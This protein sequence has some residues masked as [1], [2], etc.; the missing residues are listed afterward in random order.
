MTLTELRYVMAVAAFK[1]FGKAAKSCHV[2]QPTLSVAI[3]KLE[4][5]LNVTIFER[6]N[7]AVRITDVGHML[8]QQTQHVLEEVDK[9]KNVSRDA[10]SQL[11]E[12]L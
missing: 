3:S 10:K 2:S 4:K 8:I 9:L 1:H 6:H 12:P 7:N 5:E 11:T